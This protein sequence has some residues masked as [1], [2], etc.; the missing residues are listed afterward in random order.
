MSIQPL[1][2]LDI[3]N[4][5]ALREWCSRKVQ[6]LPAKPTSQRMQ[7][8]CWEKSHGL[9]QYIEIYGN[10]AYEYIKILMTQCSATK[11]VY[12]WAEL[13]DYEAV[14]RSQAKTFIK[15]CDNILKDLES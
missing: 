7:C 1:K 2:L 6:Q 3:I 10:E 4:D 13:P 14:K 9:L 5:V 8:S 15:D 12:Y 11:V